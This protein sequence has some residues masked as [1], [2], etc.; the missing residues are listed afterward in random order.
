MSLK[1]L[2]VDDE[3]LSRS[4]IHDLLDEY[5]PDANVAEAAD[6]A[7]ALLFLEQNEINV[8]FLDVQMPET[9]GFELLEQAGRRRFEVVFI[10]AHSAYAIPALRE[11][12]ADYLLKPVRKS[13]FKGMVERLVKR[14]SPASSVQNPA[15][16]AISYLDRQLTLTHQH[17]F[18]LVS[19]GEIVYLKADNSYTLFFLT[20]GRKSIASKPLSHYTRILD[21]AH[22]FRVHK[23]Y[24]VNLAHVAAYDTEGGEHVLMNNDERIRISRYR[25]AEFLER[26]RCRNDILRT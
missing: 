15:S 20:G 26:L 17:G 25:L 9:D 18:R 6:A 14:L 4:Y 21:A 13:E 10:T 5:L 3:R 8:L 19:L 12:A 23:S 2:I 24:L 16:P 7:S 1:I 22:F 11:G